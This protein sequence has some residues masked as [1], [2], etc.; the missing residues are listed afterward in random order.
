MNNKCEFYKMIAEIALDFA[1]AEEYLGSMVLIMSVGIG[2]IE[3][4]KL[5]RKICRGMLFNEKIKKLEEIDKD[6]TKE[7]ITNLNEMGKIRNSI[8][9]TNI[10]R[11]DSLPIT[12]YDATL[13]MSCSSDNKVKDD[14][15]ARLQEL[16]EA[17]RI[18]KYNYS[19]SV[20][21]YSKLAEQYSIPKNELNE[22]VK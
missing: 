9:H 6:K 19:K 4:D 20:D 11:Q 15:E 16:R 7:Y 10:Y 5:R 14:A 21:E 8:M 3:Y 18:F 1:N 2:G 12:Q 22:N 17:Y 13:S